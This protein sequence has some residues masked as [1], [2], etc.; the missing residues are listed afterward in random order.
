MSKDY[1][2]NNKNSKN[3]SNTIYNGAQFGF[4]NK[5][6]SSDGDN[7]HG[8]WI[9]GWNYSSKRGKITLSGVEN[10]RSK[11]YKG[12]QNGKQHI[13]LFVEVFYHNTGA[14]VVE[15]IDFCIDSGTAMMDKMG[16]L[17][18]TKSR[19]GGSWTNRVNPNNYNR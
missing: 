8:F 16:M 1:S 2:K 15:Y 5:I 3:N 4:S 18:N 10:K 12:K 19:K 9:N 17:I 7:D 13:M 6:K 14:T 11:R